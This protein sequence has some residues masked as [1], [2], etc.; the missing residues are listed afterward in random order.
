MFASST[1]WNEPDRI[2]SNLN[3]KNKSNIYP[4]ANLQNKK[5]TSSG[6]NI[7]INHLENN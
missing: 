1:H 3:G 2:E 7:I 4:K 6:H 5:S